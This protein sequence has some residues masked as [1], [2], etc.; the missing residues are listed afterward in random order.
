MRFEDAWFSDR[1]LKVAP[2]NVVARSN[3]GGGEAGELA[4]S[5]GLISQCPIIT[6][7]TLTRRRRADMVRQLHD[8]DLEAA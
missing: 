7:Y 3:F 6:S 1:L 5:T 8:F 4:A 2:L